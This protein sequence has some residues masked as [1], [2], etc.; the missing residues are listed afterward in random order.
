[1][2]AESV[3]AGLR[4]LDLTDH[5]GA[6][7]GR[8]LADM[9]ADVIKVEPPGGDPAR[10]VGPF[11]D[12]QPHLDRSLFFWF[13]NLNKR[14]MTLDLNT[15]KG[16]EIF[17]RLAQAADL[18]IESFAPGRMAELGLGWERL[19]AINPALILCSIAPFG[20]TGPYRD[21]QANDSVL[22]ALGGMLYVCGYPGEKPVRP[23]GLQAYHSGSYY[24]VIGIMGALFARSS[25]AAGQWVDVS[26]QEATASAV[27]HLAGRYFGENDIPRRYGTMHWMRGFR[28]ARCRNG[29]VMHSISGDWNT[30]LEWI[31]SDGKA[32]ELT[33]PQW[34]E[35][36]YRRANF[37]RLYAILDEW[38]KDKDR[39][40]LAARAQTLRL[41][42]AAVRS[43]D[44]LSS[45]EQLAARGYF[46]EVEH[47]ELGRSFRYPGAPCV[48]SATPW[49][50]YRR[51]PLVGEHTAEILERELGIGARDL[52]GLRADK[53]I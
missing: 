50:V 35:D 43:F 47:P 28:V 25:N 12:H 11:L 41:P 15:N 5:K 34:N 45:D 46:V 16:V 27:E 31:K 8:M 1:M 52:A 7:C 10:Q 22:A 14:S 2:T 24:A 53:V 36:A 44:E 20:Q 13:Y 42:Y 49:R 18:V 3:F 51:P 33:Q 4:V 38:V 37:E 9:G 21:Y 6:L 19:H 30:L 48:F 32:Q 26:I 39:D 40:E 29:Y 23:V 17:L